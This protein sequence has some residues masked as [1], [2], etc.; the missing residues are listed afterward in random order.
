MIRLPGATEKKYRTRRQ[1]K[2]VTGVVLHQMGFSRGDSWAKYINVAAHYCVLPGGEVLQLHDHETILFASN[3]LNRT[4]V[5]IEFAG[6]FQDKNG[7]WWRPETY[8]RDVLTD[9]QIASGR[10]LVLSLISGNSDLSFSIWAHCQAAGVRKG[11]CCGPE[12]WRAIGE[13]FLDLK[14]VPDMR[15]ETIGKK[16]IP[17]PKEWWHQ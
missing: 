14:L 5:A 1:A 3:G 11:N 9:A 6:N 13:Y 4:T 7:R 2:N 10:E 8:G 12:I 17:I 15:N 16:G